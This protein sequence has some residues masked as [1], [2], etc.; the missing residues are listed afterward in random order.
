MLNT[1]GF[2]VL[3]S[4]AHTAETIALVKNRECVEMAVHLHVSRLLGGLT[5]LP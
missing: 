4:S 3:P 1:N 5:A 2:K